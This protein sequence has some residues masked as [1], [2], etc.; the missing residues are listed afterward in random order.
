MSWTGAEA[1]DDITA[2]TNLFP[3]NSHDQTLRSGYGHRDCHMHAAAFSHVQKRSL[4]RA[5]RRAQLTGCAWYRGKCFTADQFPSVHPPKPDRR[6]KMHPVRYNKHFAPRHR[7]QVGQV[8]VGGLSQQRLQEVKHW[9]LAAEIDVLVVQE[10]R[11]SF[12]AEWSD[13]HWHHVHTGTA[14]DRANGLLFLIQT[15]VCPP[16]AIGF[17][18][19]M[20]GRIGHLRIHQARRSVDIL[21]CYQHSDDHSTHRQQ[22]RKDFWGLLDQTISM[23]PNRNSLLIA[24]DFNCSL[25]QTHPFVGTTC[26][27]RDHRLCHGPRHKDMHCFIEILRKYHLNAVNSWNA[28]HPPTFV[29]GLHDSRIDHFLMRH[30][31]VDQHALDVKFFPQAGFLPLTGAHHIPM[32]CSIRK[33]PHVY[34]KTAQQG[35]C[36]FQQRLKSRQA[37][38]SNTHTWQEF[39]EAFRQNFTAFTLQQ[40][41]R[42]TLIDEMH[43]HLMPTFHQFF[44]P[45]MSS[46][47]TESQSKQQQLIRA[48]WNHRAMM[49]QHCETSIKAIFHAW[50]HF[51][52]FRKMKWEL[53]I[54]SEHIRKQKMQD[55]MD[56]VSHAATRNDSFAVYQAVMK[57]TPKQPRKRIRIRLPNGT[58]ASPMEVLD[59][60]SAYIKEL[61]LPATT[62]DI[63]ITRPPGVPFTKDALIREL[64]QT[65]VTKAVAR[66]CLPGICWKTAAHAVANYIY[67]KLEEWWGSLPI[68]IPSQWKTAHLTFIH[69]PG[70][71]PDRLGHLRPLALL[72]PVGKSILGLLTTL[73]ATEVKPLICS[74]PQLAFLPQRSTYDAI[75]R[76]IL[77]CEQ[78][79][80]LTM[81]QRR[82]V[83]Q[84]AADYQC[85]PICGG[86]QVCL[87][88]SKAFDMVPRQPL[89]DFLGSLDINQDLVAILAMWHSN[90]SY[91][92]TQGATSTAVGTGRGVRQGCRAAPVLWSSY[93]LALFIR[94]SRQLGPE[95]VKKQLTM[96]ADDLHSCDCFLNETELQLA[97]KRIGILLDVIEDMGLTLALD[98]SHAM[99]SIGGTNCRD[100]SRKIIQVDSQGPHLLIPRAGGRVSRLPLCSHTKYLGVHIGYRLFEKHTVQHRIHAANITFSRLR[101]W[102]RCKRIGLKY[103]LHMWRACVLSTLT[104]GIFSV[105][106][107]LRDALLLQQCIFK[108]YRVMVGD[109]SFLT[110]HSHVHIL[111]QYQLEHPLLLL[112]HA[113]TQLKST[114]GQ[115]LNL[116]QADDILWTAD[117]THLSALLQLLHSAYNE[118]FQVH[119]HTPANEVRLQMHVCPHCPCIFDSLP[120]LRR[121]LTH[122]HGRMV[123]RTTLVD[124]AAFATRGLPQCAHCHE[125]FPSWR[126]FCVHL[127][128][129][130]CQALTINGSE[131][132]CS[133]QDHKMQEDTRLPKLTAQHLTLLHSKPYGQPLLDCITERRWDDLQSL[134]RALKDL[135]HYCILCGMY[136]GRPQE[137]NQHLR[138]QHG[139]L[140][141]HV[142]SKASQLCR[143]QASNSP[144]RFCDRE[145]RRTHQCPIMTQAA[146]I[147]VNT[148]STGTSY[149][150]PGHQVLRCDVCG[151]QHHDLRSLHAHLHQE[152][153]LDTQDWDPL[154]DMLLG[155]NPVCSHCMQMF[156]DKSA[157]RHHITLG[158][159][160]SFNPL[161][162]PATVPITDEWQELLFQG[163]I[164]SLRQA[165]MKRLALTLTCQLCQLKFQRAGDLSLHLQQVHHQEWHDAM[166][167]V[168]LLIASCQ[169]DGCLCNPQTN[170][171]G[172]QHVCVP[173]RQLGMMALKTTIPVLLPWKFEEDHIHQFLIALA[174]HPLLPRLTACLMQRQ[175]TQL[176]TDP[177]CLEFFRTTCL[178]CGMSMHPAELR[179]HIFSVHSS[180]A[181]MHDKILPQ[182]IHAIQSEA[183]ADH[184]CDVCLQIFNHPIT[185]DETDMASRKL[186]AQ[187]HYQH[188]CPV[189]LQL[190]HL[191]RKDYGSSSRNQSGGHRDVGCLQTPQPPAEASEVRQNRRRHREQKG[192]TGQ[193]KKGRRHGGDDSVDGNGPPSSASGRRPTSDEKTRLMG[194]L[195]ANGLPGT[196]AIAGSESDGVEIPAEGAGPIQDGAVHPSTLL[197]GPTPGGHDAEQADQTGSM[198][199][200][201]PVE[202]VSPTT[203]SADAGQCL[204]FPQVESS[205]TGAPTDRTITNPSQEDDQVCRTTGGDPQGPFSDHT[206]PLDETDVQGLQPGLHHPMDVANIHAC[207]RSTSSVDNV[208]RIDDVEP[209]GPVDEEPRPNPEQ[210]SLGTTGSHGQGLGQIEVQGQDQDQAGPLTDPMPDTPAISRRQLLDGLA[211]LQLVNDTNWCYMNASFMT[212]LWSLL[213]TDQFSLSQWGPSGTQ[214]AHL[215]MTHN[216]EPVDL[217]SITCLQNIIATWQGAGQQGD[218]VEFLA[219][220]MQRLGIAGIDMRWEKRIQIGLLTD[221]VDSNATYTPMVLQ[222]DPMLLNDDATSLRQLIRDWSNQDGMMRALTHDSP[223]IY[224]QIDRHIRSGAGHITKCDI[225]VNFHWGIEVPVYTGTD[226]TVHWKTYKVVAAVAHLG[227]DASDHCRALLRVQMQ[228]NTTNPH[229]FLLTDDWVP[230][231]PVW[232]EPTWFTRNATCFWLCDFDHMS[233][234]DLAAHT[235]QTPRP[236]DPNTRLGAQ[237][238][239]SMFVD[240]T[241]VGAAT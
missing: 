14:D 199:R 186:L 233:L 30:A 64:A 178:Q 5:I 69:K 34:T 9:A 156:A 3:A 31:D 123:F 169:P 213:S 108:M 230:A 163:D 54:H 86:V 201:R 36:T 35:T 139:Q 157:V 170:A 172:L 49:R 229:M 174:D 58:P 116:L 145:F 27:T 211:K 183:T 17:A 191:L 181:I 236:P 71:Q 187:I 180:A 90:T 109:Y 133:K 200:D 15:S 29:N 126:N 1:E 166:N 197:P 96:F 158:Q 228:S 165:P 114:I 142:L 224:V 24:G 6:P 149:E 80:R 70:K 52:Q 99:I 132:L 72:E 235:G 56:E 173:L 84:R 104:Y 194:L 100:I 125:T 162:Q 150:Q 205:C 85:R 89:F 212:L 135:T 175:F 128:R 91:I 61:W 226:L 190:V 26:Y 83:H 144:C 110:G 46:T 118:Q 146:L 131:F 140:L 4:R 43:Q 220:L 225:P 207:R 20:P 53:H 103:R 25:Q 221:T 65:P 216:S 28:K 141:P 153:R 32:L 217:S 51:G 16:D 47:A 152:H 159:C 78:V 177:L 179:D 154:R 143:S 239:L 222:F 7:L 12:E 75:R 98:K 63:S 11:W 127:E 232:K 2:W 168:Q 121:H 214:L 171:S 203:W 10:T 92:V 41:D 155:T 39:H 117:W 97:L 87:D 18:S 237:D 136:S 134:S 164:Q 107:T 19:A 208:A 231:V 44:R 129:N 204:S 241:D 42:E 102:L 227:A 62:I 106:F 76:V 77:H 115:R 38:V 151:L 119:L 167:L 66:T 22:L 105:G 48:K 219:H 122:V 82:S 196:L 147:L 55:L 138:I 198:R 148:D 23:I 101:R 185:A 188:Q 95:W 45:Q 192:Q 13:Q 195:H 81:N 238:L 57:Y 93:T 124:V 184:K 50:W 206:I 218:P 161:R 59:L 137:L 130:C 234:H 160:P 112:L 88:A 202:D 8:N 33:V 210:A 67:P 209:T 21:G 120:N 223:L 189:V 68:F 73:F 176:W 111:Q 193:R 74:W 215:L 182:L 113:G 37:W 240:G 79:R 40:P 94:L 60:T